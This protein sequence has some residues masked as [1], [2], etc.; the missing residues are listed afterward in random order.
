M[1]AEIATA[2]FRLRKFCLSLPWVVST[3]VTKLKS[4]RGCSNF[5]DA[6]EDLVVCSS[7]SVVLFGLVP[8]V[9]GWAR[10][11]EGSMRSFPGIH[12]SALGG[13]WSV[14]NDLA[15][16]VGLFGHADSKQNLKELRILASEDC[17]LFADLNKNRDKADLSTLVPRAVLS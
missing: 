9:T 11:C 17:C 12:R 3:V 10:L 16:R 5:L 1:A 14:S 2:T 7:V 4:P 6:E 13:F 8:S 15:G